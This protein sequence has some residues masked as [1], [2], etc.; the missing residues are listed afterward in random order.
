MKVGH[1][2][3]GQRAEEAREGRRLDPWFLP[4]VFSFPGSRLWVAPRSLSTGI[5]DTGFRG[6]AP[7]RGPGD[8]EDPR[9]GLRQQP[10][11]RDGS[12]STSLGS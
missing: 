3:G 2:W 5:S 7:P 1:W 9:E 4:A 11:D 12:A 8:G 10:P 6:A